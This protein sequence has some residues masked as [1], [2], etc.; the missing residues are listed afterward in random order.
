MK[1]S[2]ETRTGAIDARLTKRE[3]RLSGIGDRREEM[4]IFIK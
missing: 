2:V 1:K 3:E 4:G